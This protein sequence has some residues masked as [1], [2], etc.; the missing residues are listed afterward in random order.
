MPISEFGDRVVVL[1]QE[2]W[3]VRKFVNFQYGALNPENRAHQSVIDNL[4]K[5]GAYKVLASPLQGRK[6][7]D[8]DICSVVKKAV[9]SVGTENEFELFWESYP[10]KVGKKPSL[11]AWHKLKLS[12]AAAAALMAA[13]EKQKN[14]EKWLGGY[15]P[16]PLTW[17]NQERWNDEV[18]ENHEQKINA[19]LVAKD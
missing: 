18:A 3:L 12:P 6:D 9:V 10:L 7:K 13:L 16:N 4:Q 15:V 2:K 14:S 5:E 17:L 8:K 1:S 11:K 19:N